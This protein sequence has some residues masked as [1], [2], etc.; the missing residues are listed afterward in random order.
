MD[1]AETLTASSLIATLPLPVVHLPFEAG[2]Y[3]M[4]MGLT[5]VPPDD[6][7]VIDRLYPDEM[8]QR[9]ALLAEKP[10][11]VLAGL[12]EAEPACT[13][14]Y[15]TLASFLP[16]RFPAWFT[17]TETHLENHLTHETWP[18]HATG[19]AALE[20]AGRLVQE[21]LCLLQ[22]HGETPH[23][24]AGI[25]CFPSGWRLTEKLG[26]PLAAVHGPV[27]IYPDRLARPVDRL[28]STLRDGKLVERVNWTI[29]DSP[30]LHRPG[31]HFRRIPNPN[32]TA[33]NAGDLLYLRCERQTLRRLPH[34][35]AVLFAI[36]TYVHP[37]AQ[38]IT[39]PESAARLASAIRGIPEELAAYKSL[40]IHRQPALQYLDR[41]SPP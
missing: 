35:N 10:A 9:R 1:N 5:A 18:L 8:A 31:G 11:E 24:T 13:E 17:R 30:T 7:I 4:S 27:P 33:E 12:P 16:A 6:L 29:L 38:V 28:M 37:L 41:L 20:I 26:L 21:D 14:L 34:T 2:P 3:R 32:L 40:G 25:L 36:R 23:L 39:T 22:L 15:Q 19:L